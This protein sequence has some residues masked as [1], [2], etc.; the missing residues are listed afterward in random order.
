[1]LHLKKAAGPQRAQKANIIPTVLGTERGP[2]SIS[3]G[4]SDN[5]PRMRPQGGNVDDDRGVDMHRHA[6]DK[7]F[8]EE[9]ARQRIFARSG[10]CEFQHPPETTTRPGAVEQGDLDDGRSRTEITDVGGRNNGST[11]EP[12]LPSKSD[13][14]DHARSHWYSANHQAHEPTAL[15]PSPKSRDF[16][17]AALPQAAQRALRNSML[18]SGELSRHWRRRRDS[19][20]TQAAWSARQRRSHQRA[21]AVGITDVG[22]ETAEYGEGRRDRG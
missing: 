6:R 17:I 14:E 18:R 16:D 12:D 2:R 10:R 15:A 8:R 9:R 21:A 22:R 4:R 19:A 5:R 11:L 13:G 7:R 20:E 3:I 1:M